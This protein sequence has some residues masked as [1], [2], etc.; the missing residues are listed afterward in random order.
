LKTPDRGYAFRLSVT[1]ERLRAQVSLLQY[2]SAEL[3]ELNRQR[4]AHTKGA[5]I[6]LKDCL[7]LTADELR[8]TAQELQKDEEEKEK[9]KAAKATKPRKPRKRKAK[10]MEAPIQQEVNSADNDVES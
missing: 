2:V 3:K 6:A 1:T 10:E 7:L 5:R 8:K 4:K 9:L